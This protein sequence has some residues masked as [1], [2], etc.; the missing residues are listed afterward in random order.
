MHGPTMITIDC[1]DMRELKV[2]LAAYISERTKV[3]ALMKSDEIVLDS[4]TDDVADV[5]DV[6]QHV[7]AFLAMKDLSKDFLVK[8][9]GKKIIIVSISGRKVTRT[10]KDLELLECPHCGMLSPYEEE[11]SVHLK[12]HYIGF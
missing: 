12:A 2:E 9:K 6:S 8:V 1:H 5:N 4:L 11:M 10:D 3:V 7:T